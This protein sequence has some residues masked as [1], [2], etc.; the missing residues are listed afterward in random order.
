[1]PGDAFNGGGYV[2]KVIERMS[3][4]EAKSKVGGK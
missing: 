2:E 1:L 4:V 3:A